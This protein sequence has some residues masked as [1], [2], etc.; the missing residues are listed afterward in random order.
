MYREIPMLKLKASS[1]KMRFS[2]QMS[3]EL[4]TLE[5]MLGHPRNLTIQIKTDFTEMIFR[6]KVNRAKYIR[7][8]D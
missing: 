3:C 1:I 2:E 5:Q 8:K 6:A 4:M 7:K